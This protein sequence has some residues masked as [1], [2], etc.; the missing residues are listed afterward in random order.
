[1]KE[2]GS[3]RK[4]LLGIIAGLA[5][6]ITIIYLSYLN[7]K[8]FE[9]T[10]V[11][12]EQHQLLTIA[13]TAASRLEDYMVEHLGSLK[14]ISMNPLVQVRAK[15]CKEKPLKE[16]EHFRPCR[17]Y[18]PI[19][20]L[21]KIDESGVDALTF[22]DANGVVLCTHPYVQGRIGADCAEKPDIAHVLR[23]HKP[24]VGEVF[25]HDL[26]GVISISEPVF[27]EGE[28]AGIIQWTI[29][30]DNLYKRFIQPIKV[31]RESFV[32][33]LGQKK[34]I[35][36]TPLR[37]PDLK[38]VGDDIMASRKEAFPDY[39]WSELEDIVEKATRGEE[40]VGIYDCP[41][42]GKRLIAY[43]PIRM[44]THLWSIGIAMDYSEI[45]VPIY[46]HARNT[47][48]LSGLVILLFGAG[49]IALLRIQKRKADL[50]AE[51]KYLKHIAES[52]E[53]LRKSEQRFRDLVENC[54]TGIFIIQDDQIVYKNPE[55]ERLFGPL[56]ESFKFTDF[57]NIHPDDVEKFKQF[58]QRV[59]SGDARTLDTEFRFYSAGKLDGGVNMRWVH[60]RAS[61]IEYQ[62]E[63]ILVNMMDIT[64]A[65]ELEHLV[66]IR[67]K[68]ASLGHVAAGIAHEIR[69][70]LSGINVYLATLKKIYD[71]SDSFEP[72]T[73]EKVKRI[74]GQLQS[75]SNKIELVI[76]KVMDFSRPSTPNLALTD[77]NESIEEA[78]NLSSVTLRKSGIKLEKS[79]ARNLP[80]CYA[81]SHLIEQVLLNLITNAAQ[82]MK[83][84]DG[85]Q[86]IEITSSQENNHIIIRVS[87][88]G[89][90]MPSNIRDK[91]F[92]PFFTTK[93]DS[94][95]IGLSLSHRIITDHGGSLDVFRSKWGGAE[96]RIKIPVEKR[97]S[98][99]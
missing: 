92:D 91:I 77:I 18:C 73:L 64:R 49:C 88:S 36:S 97:M 4:V 19:K 86:R 23:E 56:P 60:C 78:V 98:R 52:A 90:G 51:T 8:A 55:Q 12:Q 70:P 43:A 75:A 74:V 96:F 84:I 69:N 42:C 54:L 38:Q 83:M 5:I 87:D 11:S 39:D 47:F 65:K 3:S 76:R 32:W 10:I 13:K 20:T 26:G 30:L 22:F 46:A 40:G 15:I 63:A 44:G 29:T 66:S 71:S 57:E 89:P 9:R 45:A 80:R 82:A 35:L 24:Y 68:M 62:G 14:T 94:S 31:G 58:Y 21:Y 1:M 93:S 95:G 37:H 27:Y 33:I 53:A 25:H 67:Q 17:K 34:T 81:D 48:G 16:T 50:E 99:K 41:T 28:F 61:L 79:L 7:Q 85:P 72:E 59:L 2:H 6:I